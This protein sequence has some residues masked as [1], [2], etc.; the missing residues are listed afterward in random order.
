MIPRQLNLK[1]FLSYRQATLD[2]RGLHTACI[3]GANGA[4]KSSLLEAITWVIWGQTRTATE[5]D[6]IHAGEKN[7]RVDFEFI[8]NC[9]TYRII[10]TRQRRGG[11]T[12]DFQIENEGQF[13]S[14]SEKGIRAT[15]Q[16][17][18]E[19]LKLDY[20][21]FIN[22]AYLRQGRAD[23]FML[24]RPSERK[25]ILADL[26]KL[27]QYENLATQAK[28]LAKQY[29]GKADEL[30]YNLQEIESNLQARAVI[31]DRLNNTAKELK[32]FQATHKKAQEKLRRLQAVYHQRQ[33]WEER[34]NW[35]QNHDDNLTKKIRQIREERQII[36]TQLTQLAPLLN[37]AG[38]IN[39]GYQ[40]LQQ[41][42]Q[43]EANLRD[44]FQAYQN[45][46]QQKQE[47][48]QQ[49]RD[50]SNNLI[51]A[52]QRE[53][54]NLENLE[55][56]EEELKIT[57]EKAGKIQPALQKLSHYRQRLQ[58]LDRVQHQVA[59]L[60][61]RCL[62]LRT[63]L[64]RE[65]AKLHAK[66]EQLQEQENYLN[67]LLAKV[68]E[69]RQELL[70][71]E[72]QLEELEKKRNYQRR[73]E[74]KE[75]TQRSFQQRY[76][77]NQ[78]NLARQLEEVRHKL[79]LLAEEGAACPLCE[80]ELDEN[81]RN[82]VREKTLKEQKQIENESWRYGEQI[83]TC[84]RELTNL[85]A[86]GDNLRKKLAIEDSLKQ[87]YAKLEEQLDNSGDTYIK[88]QKIRTEK[89]A[90][91]TLLNSGNYA[92]ELQDELQ[93]L[94]QQI[95]SLNYDEQTHSLVRQEEKR[96]RRAEIQKA[97]LDEAQGKYDKIQP[98]KPQKIQQIAALEAQL[99]QLTETSPIQEKIREKEAYLQQLNY[100]DRQHNQ[101]RN[102]LKKTLIYQQ[103][104][105]EL[106]QAKNLEPQLKKKL[107]KLAAEL[108]SLE[109]EKAATKE[110]L[111]SIAK[112]IE[113][114]ADCR[115]DI[116]ILEQECADRQQ[117]IDNFLTKKGGLEQSLT[118]LDN[119][120][121]EYENIS[122]RLQEVRKNYRIYQELGQAFGKNGLQALMIENVLPQLEAEANQI[123]ARL[124]GNQLHV[125]FKTQKERAN[126]FQKKS[127][128]L[129]D[130]L[131]IIISDAQGTRSY[132]TYSGGEAFRIN[133]SIRLAL[134]KL[135]AQRAGTY[136][137]FLI[138]DEGFGTQDAE[139]CDRLI[140][141][142]NAIASDFTCILT[143]THMPQFKE[144][145]QT[146]IEV[147]KTNQGSQLSLST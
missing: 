35:H 133:F 90:L 7:V 136:L 98:E 105:T 41:L 123:L 1:N 79:N 15:Q 92:R 28:D 2:F 142:L 104:Y 17:I 100:D 8:Y 113:Q 109:G 68:P 128:K 97:Q 63:G 18:I 75:L 11:S 140:A 99:Q 59:P 53:K 56:Q 143:V 132:E 26:L 54:T 65:A 118:N 117:I 10:R 122:N 73:V 76:E 61:Q 6:V 14:I 40:Q 101:V 119:L 93:L 3:C 129:I 30:A 31:T 49:L 126:R 55:R 16:R 78:L 9:Q 141:A 135:L 145:F 95:T 32:Q 87:K 134:A 91:E 47:L 42:Q 103:K 110:Q 38:E 5:E 4:G 62:T 23:E 77:E 127:A 86:E 48:E 21:T 111:E 146:R 44:K 27:N 106:Q 67:E 121:T 88:A 80:R 12:L 70:T 131:D 25:Q 57:I 137:Q 29:Q 72:G 120:Q 22:S 125:Q 138:V 108:K 33:S 69:K 116:Q 81:H 58:E 20:D 71:I 139:G 66:L 52:I 107:E 46:L 13:N 130:T 83:R 82:Y 94:E 19:C 37:N 36:E 96:W 102:N 34:L 85:R 50:K 89:E 74:E 24:R 147:Q 60:Q 51:L 39:T 115:K 114:F 124:T 64:E 144:A 84:E 112:Q 45:A 43:E